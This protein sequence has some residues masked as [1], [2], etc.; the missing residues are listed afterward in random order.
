MTCRVC[1]KR[2]AEAR[3]LFERFEV[4]QTPEHGSWLNVAEIF[5]STL[6]RQCLDQRVGSIAALHTTVSAGLASRPNRKANW[7]FHHGRRWNQAIPAL[8]F[9]SVESR[10]Q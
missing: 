3:G 7:R 10:Y 9:H 8:P 2:S 1:A 6:S 4:H 5:L